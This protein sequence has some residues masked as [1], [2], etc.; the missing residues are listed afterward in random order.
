MDLS[1]LRPFKFFSWRSSPSG[2][3][4]TTN[5]DEQPQNT[6]AQTVTSDESGGKRGESVPLVVKSSNFDPLFAT[7]K[8]NRKIYTQKLAQAVSCLSLYAYSWARHSNVIT[9][10]FRSNRGPLSHWP[11]SHRQAS[12]YARC[13]SKRR[14]YLV[15]HFG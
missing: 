15:R 10:I 14:R 2:V 13:T 5:A 8:R 4:R 1:A 12:G 6:S 9:Q 3:T 11:L 7:S